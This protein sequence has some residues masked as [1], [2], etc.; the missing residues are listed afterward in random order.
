MKIFVSILLTVLLAGAVQPIHESQAAPSDMIPKKSKLSVPN[1]KNG[2]LP[3]P[4]KKSKKKWMKPAPAPVKP[5]PIP[6]PM[7][8]LKK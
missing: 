7:P 6:R 5:I 2:L 1:H 4:D 3:L 8:Y